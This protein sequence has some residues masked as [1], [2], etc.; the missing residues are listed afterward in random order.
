[1]KYKEFE[2]II[3]AQR[4]RKY[5]V[6]CG[7]DTKKAMTLYRYNLELSKEM[8]TVISCFEVALRNRIN[9]VLV[10]HLGNEWLKD[11]ILRGGIFNVDTR[12]AN[13]KK[14]IEK[15]Y[16]GLLKD[17]KYSHHKLLAEMEFGIWKYMYAAPQYALTGN[18]L[19]D[20]FPNKPKTTVNIQFDNS[21]VFRELDYI[22]KLRNR[23]AHHEPICFNKNQNLDLTYVKNR[24]S[25]MIWL[26][27]WMNIDSASLLYG[28][29][30]IDKIVK[31]IEAL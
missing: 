9:N 30:H 4:M 23:I 16:N 3:S 6:A 24:H 8:F 2:N 14:I 26:L 13:T 29:D 7:G 10:N 27:Q 28:L 31:K 20:V 18:V 5:L 25:R 21:Y 1:M 12:V 22:N 19:L 11:S 15:A 17:G